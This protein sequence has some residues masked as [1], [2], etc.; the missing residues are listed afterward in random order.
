M[1][2]NVGQL[3]E[4]IVRPA[5]KQMGAH[6]PAAEQ[7]VLGTCAKESAL[8]TYVHQVGG[9][10][11]LGI[12]QMEPAT[13]DNIWNQYLND[14]DSLK[15]MILG[16]C[17]Y[18]SVP[19][20]D[21]LMTD[22]KLATMMCRVK[23]LWIKAKLPNYGDIDGQAHYWAKYYNGNPVTGIPQKYIDTYNQYVGGYYAK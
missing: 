13:Y 11:A 10:P 14:H 20:E 18:T 15:R 3:T 5:L 7:L 9:G 12:F 17:G 1:A 8:G 23:Y 6:S 22:Y 2:M 16:A 19:H 4:L 21:R